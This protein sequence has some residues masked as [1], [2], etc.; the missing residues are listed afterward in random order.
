MEDKTV[1]CY[2]GDDVRFLSA[3]LV[4]QYPNQEAL[5]LGL[6]AETQG[7]PVFERFSS[8]DRFRKITE[9]MGDLYEKKNQDY[10]N[11]N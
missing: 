9:Y 7:K 11:V 8:V 4:P 2:D 5:G 6:S 1:R 10:G 3:S